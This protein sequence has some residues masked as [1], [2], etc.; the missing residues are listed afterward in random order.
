MTLQGIFD[1]LKVQT[2]YVTVV[3]V[4]KGTDQLC[5]FSISDR[6]KY[7]VQIHATGK[8]LESVLDSLRM[9]GIA[10]IA[11]TF[12][13]NHRPFDIKKDYESKLQDPKFADWFK[14][15]S[16]E[17]VLVPDTNSILNHQFSSLE[18]ALG[19]TL[20]KDVRIMIPRLVILEME[21]QAN[22]AKDLLQKR[23]VML[24]FSE[25]MFLKT[26]R[27]DLFPDLEDELLANFSKIASDF[28]ADSWIRREINRYPI[29]FAK[30][31]QE[32]GGSSTIPQKPPFLLITS[33]MV[34]SFSSTAE[35]ID[36][37]YISKVENGQS[38]NIDFDRVTAFLLKLSVLL[39]E[40]IVMIDSE[41]YDLTG[42]WSG[43]STSELMNGSISI[44]PVETKS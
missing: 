38:G 15:I 13:D 41:T 22:Y 18:L 25:I 40:I 2:G 21:R 9:S 8:N 29:N 28:S 17:K 14:I 30:R 33:D 24:G 35:N 1:R 10:N 5:I 12:T 31:K 23:K 6:D 16:S 19:S 11:F 7:N 34:N 37:L 39:Q 43:I 20:L 26:K 3:K 36:T 42:F 4:F 27:V 44:T 32:I